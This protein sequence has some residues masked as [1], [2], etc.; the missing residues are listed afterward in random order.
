ML[1]PWNRNRL[2]AKLGSDYPIP[3]ESNPQFG[4]FLESGPVPDCW[5]LG[6]WPRGSPGRRQNWDYKFL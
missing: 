3:S 6:D 4:I 5:P 1:A 2:M